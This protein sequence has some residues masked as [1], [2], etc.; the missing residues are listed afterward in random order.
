MSLRII[1]HFPAERTFYKLPM[2]AAEAVDRAVITLA[3]T[4]EGELEWVAPVYI[5]ASRGLA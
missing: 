3:E 2:P 1:W 5:P 4:G